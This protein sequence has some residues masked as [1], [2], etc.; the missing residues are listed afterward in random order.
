[1]KK[2]TVFLLLL[3]SLILVSCEEADTRDPYDVLK[4]ARTEIVVAEEVSTETLLSSIGDVTIVWTSNVENTLTSDNS[5]IQTNKDIPITLTAVFSYKDVSITKLYQT[6]I[7]DIFSK[8]ADTELIHTVMNSITF[9]T[10]K[11]IEDLSLVT[12]QDGVTISWTTSDPTYLTDNGEVIQPTEDE[13]EQTVI[14]TATFTSNDETITRD[15]TFTILTSLTTV[16]Y[17][18]Y[19]SGATGLTGDDLKAFLHELIDDHTVLTY[20]QL[21]EALADSDADPTDPERVIL[22]YS[23]ASYDEDN[24]GGGTTEWNREHVWPRSHGD[25]KSTVANTDMHHIRPTKVLVNSYRGN[26]DFDE[27]G[28][29]VNETTDSYRDNDSFEPR[30]EVKGDVAR[31]LFYMAVRY[32]GAGEPDLELIDTVTSYG[33]TLGKLSVLIEWHLN[34]LPDEFEKHRND[35]IFQYQGNRNPFIDNPEFVQLIW[36]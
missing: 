6:T 4:E 21:W 16:V 10:T 11:L 33:P 34:D 8:N 27:G 12:S 36:S 28:N 3:V 2:I 24:H 32:E 14:L 18:G 23:G 15:Y 7:K 9:P 30:D 5:F 35:I 26:L 31:M 25:L 1:M 29:L 19:Y 22:L 17:E 13:G 20:D